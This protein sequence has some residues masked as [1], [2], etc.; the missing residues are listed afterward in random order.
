MCLI[1]ARVTGD[2]LRLTLH[3]TPILYDQNKATYAEL[4]YQCLTLC[5]QIVLTPLHHCGSLT[6]NSECM[7]FQHKCKA[8]KCNS[9]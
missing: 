8:L 3:L 7:H 9:C 4:C 1:H 5:K 6:Q 2:Q